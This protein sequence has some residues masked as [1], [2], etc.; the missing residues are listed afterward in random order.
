MDIEQER[1]NNIEVVKV[2]EQRLDAFN[3]PVFKEIL[4][5]IVD[6]G[7]KSLVLDLSGVE[8]IDSSGLAVMVSIMRSLGGDLRLAGIKENILKLFKATKLDKVFKV[9]VSASGAAWDVDRIL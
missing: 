8:F 2:N 9:Y 5:G 3:S 7:E 4:I 6:E 1:I